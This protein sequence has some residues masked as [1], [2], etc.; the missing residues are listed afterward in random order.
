MLHRYMFY[1][2]YI[3]YICYQCYVM[4][5]VL[6]VLP[7]VT[8]VTTCH[9]CYHMLPVLPHVTTCFQCYQCYQCYGGTKFSTG[10]RPPGRPLPTS[11]NLKSLL[12]LRIAFSRKTIASFC[13]SCIVHSSSS[14][15]TAFASPQP[16]RIFLASSASFPAVTGQDAGV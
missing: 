11:H 4:L 6:P 5:P 2:S 16:F 9:Q 13:P 1:I 15:S 7:H 10:S 8:S 3:C 14:V 12:L